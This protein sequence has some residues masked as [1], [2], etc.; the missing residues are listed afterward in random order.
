MHC[1]NE[2]K[3]IYIAKSY[4]GDK[5][6]MIETLEAKSLSSKSELW[7]TSQQ[8]LNLRIYLTSCFL[9][10]PIKHIPMSNTYCHLSNQT[11]KIIGYENANKDAFHTFNSFILMLK[12]KRSHKPNVT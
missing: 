11:S 3:R 1:V 9:S 10:M 2:N 7:S 5:S 12:R 8:F 6:K 4:N